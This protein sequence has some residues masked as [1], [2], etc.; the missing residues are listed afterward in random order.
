VDD[1]FIYEIPTNLDGTKCNFEVSNFVSN[2][3][4]EVTGF[5]WKANC[6]MN[7][8]VVK[9]GVCS[10]SVSRRDYEYPSNS[11]SEGTIQMTNRIYE[12]ALCG[13]DPLF[14]LPPTGNPTFKPSSR[15]SLLPSGSPTF[16]PISRP[17]A[18]PTTTPTTAFSFLDVDS[19]NPGLGRSTTVTYKYAVT[20]ENVWEALSLRWSNF[21]RDYIKKASDYFDISYSKLIIDVAG[22]QLGDTAPFTAMFECNGRKEIRH[23]MDAIKNN[24]TATTTC[25]GLVWRVTTEGG[26]CANCSVDASSAFLT[27]QSTYLSLPPRIWSTNFKFAARFGID[28]TLIDAPD[29]PLIEIRNS[30]WGRTNVTVTMQVTTFSPG[31]IVH[32]TALPDREWKERTYTVQQLNNGLTTTKSI[33]QSLPVGNGVHV[34]TILNLYSYVKYT[35]ACFGENLRDQLG[36]DGMQITT[37]ETKCCRK[38]SF[39]QAPAFVYSGITSDQYAFVLDAEYPGDVTF[40]LSLLPLNGTLGAAVSCPFEWSYTNNT[41]IIELRRTFFI[42]GDPGVYRMDIFPSG[43]E[44][45]LYS[46]KSTTV[47]IV[48]ERV[49]LPAPTVMRAQLTNNGISAYFIFSAGTDYAVSYFTQL[50]VFVDEWPCDRLFVFNGSELATCS[51]ENSTAVYA[52][53]NLPVFPVDGGKVHIGMKA[54]I[55]RASC[56]YADGCPSFSFNEEQIVELTGPVISPKPLIVLTAPRNVSDCSEL[57]VDAMSSMGSAGQPWKNVTWTVDAVPELETWV[58]DSVYARMQNSSRHCSSNITDFYDALVKGGTKRPIVVPSALLRSRCVYRVTLF[59]MNAFD[60]TDMKMFLTSRVI[61]HKPVVF[62]HGKNTRTI[63][64]DQELSLFADVKVPSGMGPTCSSGSPGYKDVDFKWSVYKNG[65]SD[66]I[67]QQTIA[68]S[69]ESLRFYM[70]S[71]TL[72]IGAT[73]TFVIEVSPRYATPPDPVLMTPSL[74]INSA[75]VTVHVKRGALHARMSAGSFL[76]HPID[77]ELVITSLSYDESYPLNTALDSVTRPNSSLLHHQWS[78][79]MACSGS[80]TSSCGN[81]FIGSSTAASISIPPYSIVCGINYRISLLV[82]NDMGAQDKSVTV[83]SCAPA[84]A[85]E[86]VSQSLDRSYT[87]NK[88]VKIGASIRG[89]GTCTATWSDPYRLTSIEATAETDT[90]KTFSLTP[91]SMVQYALQYRKN[92]LASGIAYNMRLVAR[93]S[94]LGAEGAVLSSQI[95]F[96]FRTLE[97]PRL[98]SM[99]VEPSEGVTLQT[100][101]KFYAQDYCHDSALYPFTYEFFCTQSIDSSRLDSMIQVRSERPFAS[102]LLPQGYS[103][104][105]FKLYVGVRVADVYTAETESLRVVTVN[106][107]EFSNFDAVVAMSDSLIES[108]T[109]DEVLNIISSVAEIA[110]VVDCTSLSDGYC[111]S[112]NREGCSGKANT[113]GICKTNYFGAPGLGNTECSSAEDISKKKASGAVCSENKECMFDEC[114]FGANAEGDLVGVCTVPE[115]RC[116]SN[117]ESKICSGHGVCQAYDFVRRKLEVCKADNACIVTCEQCE[118]PYRGIS[119]SDTIEEFEKKVALRGSLCG[120][121]YQSIPANALEIDA[122]FIVNL[123]ASVQKVFSPV[124]FSNVTAYKC[125]LLMDRIGS[126]VT[127]GTYLS[128]MTEEHVTTV[129]GALSLFAGISAENNFQ[130]PGD[131]LS[132]RWFFEIVQKIQRGMM[133]SMVQG[134]NPIQ[135]STANVRASTFSF[136]SFD[137]NGMN[138]EPPATAYDNFF[139][140]SQPSLNLGPNGIQGCGENAQLSLVRWGQSPYPNSS[141]LISPL[142]RVTIKDIEAVPPP[143]TTGV[144]SSDRYTVVQLTFVTTSNKTLEAYRAL[145]DVLTSGDFPQGL[146]ES[147]LGTIPSLRG[148]DMPVCRTRDLNGN[149]ILC[150]DCKLTGVSNSSVSYSCLDYFYQICSASLARRRLSLPNRKLQDGTDDD[151]DG[152]NSFQDGMSGDEFTSTVTALAADVIKIVSSIAQLTLA[153]AAAAFFYMFTIAGAMFS[154]YWYFRKWDERDRKQIVYVK[155]LWGEEHIHKSYEKDSQ[156]KRGYDVMKSF[157]PQISHKQEKH[158]QELL[159]LQEMESQTFLNQHEN[160]FD[161]HIASKNGFRLDKIDGVDDNTVL[162]WMETTQDNGSEWGQEPFGLDSDSGE[163]KSSAAEGTNPTTEFLNQVLPSSSVLAD[164]S[165]FLRFLQVLIREHDV[166]MLFSYGSLNFP[167]RIRFL[168]V[169]TDIVLLFFMDTVVFSAMLPTGVCE[170]I[171]DED[172]CEMLPSSFGNFQQCEWDED[173][174]CVLGEP[175]EDIMFEL[176]IGLIIMLFTVPPSLFLWF[177]CFEGVMCKRPRLEE[178]GF[179]SEYWRPSFTGGP[180]LKHVEDSVEFNPGESSQ[181]QDDGLFI[182]KRSSALAKHHCLNSNNGEVMLAETPITGALSDHSVSASK[183]GMGKDK[184]RLS[185]HVRTHGVDAKKLHLQLPGHHG[186]RHGKGHQHNVSHD[187]SHKSVEKIDSVPTAI[188]AFIKEA[189]APDVTLKRVPDEIPTNNLKRALHSKNMK[190]KDDQRVVENKRIVADITNAEAEAETLHVLAKSLALLQTPTSGGLSWEYIKDGHDAPLRGEQFSIHRKEVLATAS[191]VGMNS[192][193]SPKQLGFFARWW[194][195]SRRNY[196]K[197]CIVEAMEEEERTLEEL[198]AF[199]VDEDDCR[200]VYMMQSFILSNFASF[201]RVVLRLAL[202][203][204]D[205]AHPVSC[206]PLPWLC[207]W[208]GVISLNFALLVYLVVW[209]A[210]A[211]PFLMFLWAEM[212]VMVIFQ[213]FAFIIPLKLYMLHG[214]VIGFMRP[215][216]LAIYHNLNTVATTRMQD[217][218]ESTDFKA[219]GALVGAIRASFDPSV[220]NLASSKLLQTV[221]DSDLIECRMAQKKKKLSWSKWL[222]LLVPLTMAFASEQLGIFAMEVFGPSLWAA[223]VGANALVIEMGFPL[224]VLLVTY[225]LATFF[226]YK[227]IRQYRRMRR[228]V[229]NKSLASPDSSHVN[230]TWV[231]RTKNHITDPI[232]NKIISLKQ[233]LAPSYYSKI[234]TR[235][236]RQRLGLPFAHSLRHKLMWRNMNKHSYVQGYVLQV[237]EIEAES[238]KRR[239]ARGGTH[240]AGAIPSSVMRISASTGAR[241]AWINQDAL[242]QTIKSTLKCFHPHENTESLCKDQFDNGMCNI[243]KQ[244]V[245]GELED[246]FHVQQSLLIP[247]NISLQKQDRHDKNC[248]TKSNHRI[249]VASLSNSSSDTYSFSRSGLPTSSSLVDSRDIR[250]NI[251]YTDNISRDHVDHSSMYDSSSQLSRSSDYGQYSGSSNYDEYDSRD[252]VSYEYDTEYS[253]SWGT[254]TYSVSQPSCSFECNGLAEDQIPRR[255]YYDGISQTNGLNKEKILGQVGTDDKPSSESSGLSP[256]I[257]GSYSYYYDYLP[258]SDD[259][260][261]LPSRH[262]NTSRFPGF[263]CDDKSATHKYLVSETLMTPLYEDNLTK[264][265]G[266]GP[267]NRLELSD[268][269]TELPDDASDISGYMAYLKGEA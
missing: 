115:I 8:L 263:S 113:C 148:Y 211:P 139:N 17:S 153:Q 181:N 215:Q 109:A 236:I 137:Y 199:R 85:P 156:A 151:E 100:T 179:S 265:I 12:I 144:I 90:K 65:V 145:S 245:L 84:G 127:T 188:P 25:N 213:E 178:W 68:D 63:S 24:K 54:N 134:Q 80:A 158:N 31:G 198:S 136:Y 5:D 98:G 70:A 258:R 243:E 194:F 97:I 230:K 140:V 233:L 38:L 206:S 170:G 95:E 132:A 201:K 244:S 40:R 200:D 159:K 129:V 197:S 269:T 235:Y 231:S 124:E 210:T 74:S 77:E 224:E 204:F 56:L 216:L 222:I 267:K 123:A 51:W 260:S 1:F 175:P 106:K 15:P 212:F 149:L 76:S 42:S 220:S 240:P 93:M 86:L 10:N 48:G 3:K 189:A 61:G 118:D 241:Q 59:L 234:T 232:T 16:Q 50:G 169:F 157:L 87:T 248:I 182:Y 72:S 150:K 268:V 164:E 202:F 7:S 57:V 262:N 89:N 207:A 49:A 254:D 23:L 104:N 186:H 165:P 47:E 180:S 43:S 163:L 183:K 69:F 121:L 122:A 125:G 171:I 81:L 249:S 88:R 242:A 238:R 257:D 19:L 116:P 253:S 193:G 141:T 239:F 111:E 223:F 20:S 161:T 108:A 209:A 152:D 79:A 9:E 41:A 71:H 32:C 264:G 192:D 143:S 2:N 160:Y 78:C 205:T 37:G 128:S 226:I 217:C 167:R 214:I 133:G 195:G 18:S 83:I 44:G 53:F 261:T 75:L 35:V 73:Y 29:V 67:L 96:Q 176:F 120:T 60:K 247:S 103:S 177:T 190:G 99:V 33:P 58:P 101:F 218:D 250:D 203:H 102:T 142:F 219:C 173:Q 22:M 126:L 138:V 168:G 229:N 252:S 166:V 45:N 221:R 130:L 135:V 46:T 30:T 14:T 105:D 82:S 208:V 255:S 6:F 26:L 251:R 91:T 184:G 172:A 225:I 107:L 27:P 4:S 62:I 94:H 36:V 155:T 52:K 266:K 66:P 92:S 110:N 146:T 112:L 147:Q 256:L 162:E 196:L 55:Y 154:G 191:L 13:G 187:H 39:I 28:F 227:Y 259:N 174:G 114:T 185:Y 131:I 64:V 11:I 246:S 34:L 228:R 237:H 21:T 117:D 119:C